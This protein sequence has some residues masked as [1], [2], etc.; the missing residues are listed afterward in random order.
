ME[1]APRT[2][3]CQR[4]GE[5]VP[6]GWSLRNHL[7]Y[8][9]K[10]VNDEPYLGDIDAFAESIGDIVQEDDDEPMQ[11]Q[12]DPVE[13][14]PEDRTYIAHYLDA[15]SKVGTLDNAAIVKYV[16]WGHFN[17]TKDDIETLRFMRSMFCGTG[18]SRRTADEVLAYVHTM[19]GLSYRLPKTIDACW[20]KVEQVKKKVDPNLRS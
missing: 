17:P 6:V 1:R 8:I 11:L 12:E 18:A 13:L 14:N 7:Q 20:I 9:C 16:E 2:H 19:G 10:A 3:P 5:D 4:C 15:L